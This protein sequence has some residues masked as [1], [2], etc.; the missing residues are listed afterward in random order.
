VA[1]SILLLISNCYAVAAEVDEKV[2]SASLL[3]EISAQDGAALLQMDAATREVEV[4]SELVEGVPKIGAF[5]RLHNKAG[6][7]TGAADSN[8]TV[9]VTEHGVFSMENIYVPGRQAVEDA[10]MVYSTFMPKL[11]LPAQLPSACLTVGFAIVWLCFYIEKIYTNDRVENLHRW[12][13]AVRK[14]RKDDKDR[15]SGMVKNRKRGAARRSTASPG[16]SSLDDGDDG[17][18]KEYDDDSNPAA[19]QPDMILV[20]PVSQEA[21]GIPSGAFSPKAVARTFGSHRH[22]HS[23]L[24]SHSKPLENRLF[25]R[26]NEGI[27]QARVS[28]HAEGASLLTHHAGKGEGPSRDS[29]R[30]DLLED[31]R[32]SLPLM[33]FNVYIG[34]SSD[35]SQHFVCVSLSD[36][37]AV[38]K[39]FMLYNV[40]VQ[41]QASIAEKL[42]IQQPMDE[43]ESSPPP[44]R[45]DPRIVEGLHANN[46]IAK[47]DPR[48]LYRRYPSQGTDKDTIAVQT[49]RF[50]II[51]KELTEHLDMEALRNEGLVQDFFPAHDNPQLQ[52]LKAV[53]T[54]WASLVDLQF[55][56]PIHFIR[57]YFGSQLAFSFALLGFY[58]KMLLALVVPALLYETG[59]LTLDW[60]HSRSMRESETRQMLGFSIILTL[61]AQ[62]ASNFWDREQTFFI[63]SWGVDNADRMKVMRYKFQGELGPSPV[64]KK[65][66]EKQ[67]PPERAMLWR[68]T[69]Q[70]CAAVSCVVVTMCIFLERSILAGNVYVSSYLAIQMLV[71]EYA[72]DYLA[73]ILTDWENHK[74]H[75]EHYNSLIW[76]QAIFQ[77]VNNYYPF[78]HLIMQQSTRHSVYCWGGRWTGISSGRHGDCLT[79]LREQISLTFFFLSVFRIIQALGAC[80]WVQ[81]LRM[82][83]KRRLRQT[84]AGQGLGT[85]H[86]MSESLS[87]WWRGGTGSNSEQGPSFV[88]KQS[89]YVQF[90]DS[91]QVWTLLHPVLSL[92]HVLL[93]GAAAPIVVLL[94]FFVFAVNLRASAF[95]ISNFTKRP[96]PVDTLGVGE[97]RPVLHL[98]MKFGVVTTGFLLVTYGESFRDVPLITRL[99]GFIVYMMVAMACSAIMS[100]LCPRD[101]HSAQLLMKRRRHVERTMMRKWHHVSDNGDFSR[102]PSMLR[103]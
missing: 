24:G 33:N 1:L 82:R 92:G 29:L 75:A 7:V 77:S 90:T 5:G 52:F 91:Q 13:A 101:D 69:S 54:D 70:L 25:Q 59:I 26:I 89:E 103:G 46:V 30:A 48:Y 44:V 10:K 23:V 9:N 62:L 72:Y 18:D 86:L 78:L 22:R 50:R 58:C 43:P 32:D 74:G 41:L 66:L 93:F 65:V 68:F 21:D 88:E 36:D 102:T 15:S 38:E 6:R 64:D 37:A 2:C 98:L 67:Y 40:R 42:G 12:A 51:Y 85:L 20:L 79:V 80:L 81:F 53:W 4:D 47:N 61:W 27:A 57:E 76:K 31:L 14:C 95:L 45:Y 97:W 73:G 60:K 100:F 3:G 96:L 19:R 34:K 28:E 8:V 87:S 35:E 94:C 39:Y 11:N 63:K 99:T 56:Q 49:D 55:V 16:S 83:K 17:S 71:C 84:A